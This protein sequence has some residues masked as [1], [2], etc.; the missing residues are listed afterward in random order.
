ML[1]VDSGIAVRAALAGFAAVLEVDDDIV[2]PP[3]LWS[4]A[5]SALHEA[6]W[7]GE[8]TVAVAEEARRRLDGLRVRPRS[9]KRLGQE[10]WRIADA[11]GWK[12]TYDA[13]FVALA[14]L[15]GCHLVTI[16]G[17]LRRGA[18]RLGFVVSPAEL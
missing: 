16:D 7:R 11:L 4:E 17:R 18:D 15:L 9:P 2:A 6:R 13:E 10:A 14:S 8:L 5:R 1:V 3:L 12:K